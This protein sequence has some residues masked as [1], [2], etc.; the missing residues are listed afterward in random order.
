MKN[1]SFDFKILVIYSVLM[2]LISISLGLAD[3]FGLA[4][5]HWL[6][7]TAPIWVSAGFALAFFGFALFIEMLYEGN[8]HD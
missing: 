3:Y 6:E 2:V 1:K 7:I 8:I 4:D 5:L